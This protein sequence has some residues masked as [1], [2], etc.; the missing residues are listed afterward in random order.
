MIHGWASSLR[1]WEEI[2]PA[3]VTAG[4]KVYAP[5]LFGHGDSP[6]PDDPKMYYCQMAYATLRTWID[7]LELTQAPIMIGH[8]LGAWMCL[9]YASGHPYRVQRLILINPLFTLEQ[10]PHYARILAGNDW[11]NSVALRYAPESWIRKLTGLVPSAKANLAPEIMRR[12]SHDYKR[13]S[14]HIT[15]LT[16]TAIDLTDKLREIPTKTLIVWGEKDQTLDTAF[17]PVM[18]EM[19]PEAITFP[20]ADAGH[21][22]HQERPKIVIK[23]MM[24]FLMGMQQT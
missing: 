19:M 5:D 18:A 14:S 17:F 7:S 20:I 9:R 16:M 21:E 24:D 4:F 11:L 3:F 23:E 8:S 13:A 2:I 22:A 6:K 12:I 15:S 1:E 10:I